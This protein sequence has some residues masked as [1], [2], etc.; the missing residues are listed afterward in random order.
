MMRATAR[1]SEP[2]EASG[3]TRSPVR[4]LVTVCKALQVAAEL[5]GS[6]RFYLACRTAAVTCGFDGPNGYHT[7]ARWLKRLV[8]DGVLELVKAGI[9]G[10]NI[11]LASE[12]RFLSS[13]AR[14]T[15]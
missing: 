15:Q 10:T 12:Y 3:Y 4:R 2:L 11:R 14:K 9:G 8:S 13:Q 1:E 5:R 7:A 6:D